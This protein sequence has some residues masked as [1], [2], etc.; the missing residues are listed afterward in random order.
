MLKRF[1]VNSKI[2]NS[3]IE[4][5]KAAFHFTEGYDID[6]SGSSARIYY[7]NGFMSL[8]ETTILNHITD[9]PEKDCL[10]IEAAKVAKVFHRKEVCQSE[11]LSCVNRSAFFLK[12]V[13]I[14]CNFG[15]RFS[16]T[17]TKKMLCS[18]TVA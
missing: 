17:I 10:I 13:V 3:I 15:L 11:G 18:S 6:V 5:S 12:S 8:K 14:S 16:M 7:D 4:K 2:Y 1:K 9:H